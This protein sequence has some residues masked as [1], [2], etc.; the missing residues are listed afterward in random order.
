MQNRVFNPCQGF[1]ITE[2]QLCRVFFTI[3]VSSCH[4]W[5]YWKCFCAFLNIFF[6]FCLFLTVSWL[7]SLFST[8]SATYSFIRNSI[9]EVYN[10]GHNI[11]C[12]VEEK[13]LSSIW[14]SKCQETSCFKSSCWL[15]F[16]DEFYILVS[17]NCTPILKMSN[18]YLTCKECVRSRIT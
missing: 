13:W 4:L 2:Q 17:V 1:W 14:A 3:N 12:L 11:I 18:F 5:N 10:Y 7:Y 8:D 9:H 16:I 15:H 6:G